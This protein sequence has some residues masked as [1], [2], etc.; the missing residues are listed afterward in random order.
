MIICC[1]CCVKLWFI[2]SFIIIGVSANDDASFPWVG[3]QMLPVM[4]GSWNQHPQPH[5]SGSTVSG[6]S[7][8]WWVV[9]LFLPLH[10]HPFHSTTTSH[11]TGWGPTDPQKIPCGNIP[12]KSFIWQTTQNWKSLVGSILNQEP[13][14][15]TNHLLPSLYLVNRTT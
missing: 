6:G 1:Y 5:C 4:A 14:I 2:H 7:P 11:L 13:S 9:S 10:P 3:T 8:R 12:R 15:A